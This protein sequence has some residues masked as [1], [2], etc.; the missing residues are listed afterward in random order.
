MLFH[1]ATLPL[2]LFSR[3]ASGRPAL[4]QSSAGITVQDAMA[5]VYNTYLG[6]MGVTNGAF[7]SL[8]GGERE[9]DFSGASDDADT[10][11]TNNIIFQTADSLPHMAPFNSTGDPSFSTGYRH[12][13]Q[14]L[15]NATQDSQTPAQSQ[16]LKSLAQN[17]TVAC[18]TNFTSVT[19]DA[20][21]EYQKEGGTGNITSAV[22]IQFATQDWG[23]Y[24]LAKQACEAAQN[25]YAKAQDNI[26]GDDA[27]IIQAAIT[28]MT[29]IIDA[30]ETLYPGINMA[31]AGGEQGAV[32]DQF[33]GAYEPYY[34]LPSLNSTLVGWQT[35]PNGTKPA[36]SWDSSTDARIS[37][38]SSES[39]SAG[40]KV[41]WDSASASQSSNMS[42]VLTQAESA[43]ISFGG[44]E[45]IDVERG[46]WFDDFVT[47]S[48]VGNPA[49]DDPQA[50]QHKKAFA[51]YFGTAQNPGPASTYNDRALVVYKPQAT[52][53]FSS[54]QAYQS[55]KSAA[56]AVSVNVGL[57]SANANGQGS[58]GGQQSGNSTW[59]L[60]FTPN[61][62]NGYIVGFVMKSYWDEASNSTS[63]SDSTSDGGLEI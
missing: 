50:S 38:T 12:F 45:L 23:Q 24:T 40:V 31:V 16:E 60:A 33:N 49:S 8:F 29:P 36:I 59:Q 44:I 18:T 39:S 37:V 52:F 57:W 5:S 48:A 58:S 47:A 51:Q 32:G 63:T 56:A 25:A 6:S 7:Y 26:E 19:N 35:A 17:K 30:E 62:N 3:H 14:A 20:F 9:I 53:T 46:A 61:T 21:S 34:A 10:Y 1:T 13:I 4:R 11:M 15:Q 54:E 28:A 55:A 41:L 43:S 2:L 27:A 42:F 22:F